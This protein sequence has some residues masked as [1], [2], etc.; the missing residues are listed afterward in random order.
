[1]DCVVGAGVGDELEVGDELGVGTGVGFATATPLFQSNFLPDLVQ[2]QTLFWQVTFCR[3]T[4]QT[5]PGV[6]FVA[7]VAETGRSEKMN[8][9][10][11]NKA[12]KRLILT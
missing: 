11:I 6:I 1:M 8:T 3:Q 9:V 12:K 2:V 10:G 7:E 4:L 5:V